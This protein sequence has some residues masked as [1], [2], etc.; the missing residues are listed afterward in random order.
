[1][2]IQEFLH[3]FYVVSKQL[4]IISHIL[5]NTNAP[6]NTGSRIHVTMS[7]TGYCISFL[8][9]QKKV[10][11]SDMHWLAVVDRINFFNLAVHMTENKLNK[12]E[13]HPNYLFRQTIYKRKR[14]NEIGGMKM[15]ETVSK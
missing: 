13:L 11:K 6:N 4:S 9:Q 7:M 3:P 12:T 10:L 14:N 1:M 2:L 8:I 5:H 15:A